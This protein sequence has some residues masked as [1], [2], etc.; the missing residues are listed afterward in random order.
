MSDRREAPRAAVL[1]RS[2]GVRLPLQPLAFSARA[3]VSSRSP[4][5]A[6]GPRRRS[7][8]ACVRPITA[9]TRPRTRVEKP[10]GGLAGRTAADHFALFNA[11][12]PRHGQRSQTGVRERPNRLQLSS[13]R[14]T[15]TAL[16]STTGPARRS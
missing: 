5:A 10:V 14:T 12:P 16:Q 15:S 6:T 2:G 3:V 13:C 8:V 7:P 11:I 9:N 4:A 1:S